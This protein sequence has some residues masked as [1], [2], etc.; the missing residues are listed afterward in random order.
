MGGHEDLWILEID[1]HGH[2][3]A[4]TLTRALFL[5]TLRNGM[6]MAAFSDGSHLGVLYIARLVFEY[7]VPTLYC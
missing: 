2:I 6:S 5:V 1:P 3:R 4:T 7:K